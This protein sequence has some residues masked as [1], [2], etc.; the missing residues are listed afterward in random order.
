MQTDE[1]PC[2]LHA[3]ATK[4]VANEKTFHNGKADTLL[5][6]SELPEEE[7]IAEPSDPLRDELLALY[8]RTAN[9]EKPQPEP[10]RDNV[11]IAYMQV[12]M[13]HMCQK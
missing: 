1:V 2:K 9:N 12:N 5:E 11:N 8:R 6:T 7:M 4:S 13:F 10:D 3:E